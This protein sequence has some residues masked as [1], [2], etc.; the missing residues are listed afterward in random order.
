[1]K[2]YTFISAILISLGLIGIFVTATETPWV[3]GGSSTVEPGNCVADF[4]CSSGF[5]CVAFFCVACS[6]SPSTCEQWGSGCSIVPS[7]VGTPC[8]G[9]NTCNGGSGPSAC[10]SCASD[11]AA[12]GGSTLCCSGL[13]CDDDAPIICQTCNADNTEV[14]SG[15]CEY[16]C[17]TGVVAPV[18]D[19]LFKG[20]SVTQ[21]AN[22]GICGSSCQ[23]VNPDNP[24][25]PEAPSACAALGHQFINSGETSNHGSYAG[26]GTGG[27]CGEDSDEFSSNRTVGCTQ[28]GGPD[29]CGPSPGVY[30]YGSTNNWPD[31]TP[32]DADLVC[33]GNSNDSVYNSRCFA[34]NNDNGGPYYFDGA[35]ITFAGVGSGIT[36]NVAAENGQW[37][38]CDNSP[39]LA[40]ETL[41]TGRCNLPWIISGD[42]D[43]FVGEYDTNG[44]GSEEA[45]GDDAN[46]Y[47]IKTMVAG[48][49]LGSGYACCAASTDCVSDSNVCVS[50]GQTNPDDASLTCIVGNQFSNVD[51]DPDACVAAGFAWAINGEDFTVNGIAP[52]DYGCVGDD[53][54]EFLRYFQVESDLQAQGFSDDVFVNASCYWPDSCVHDFGN[55]GV[56]CYQKAD[57]WASRFN[58]DSS[59]YSGPGIDHNLLKSLAWKVNQSD[60]YEIQIKDLD[61]EY[62]GTDITPGSDLDNINGGLTTIRNQVDNSRLY[63]DFTGDGSPEVCDPWESSGGNVSGTITNLTSTLDL[64]TIRALDPITDAIVATTTSDVNGIYTLVLPVAG[65][66]DIEFVRNE[67]VSL[68]DFSVVVPDGGNVSKSKTMLIPADACEDDCSLIDDDV[69]HVACDGKGLCQFENDQTKSVCDGVGVGFVKDVGSGDV[70][71]CCTGA[72][73]Q[74]PIRPPASLEV[75]A[76]NLITYRKQVILDG[77]PVVMVV[78]VFDQS[79][80]R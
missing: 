59:L 17:D 18:C 8:G 79:Q 24:L 47:A 43:T 14:S 32:N 36:P 29:L 4:E 60:E 33:C 6:G 27:C 2:L 63:F 5:E 38:D 26:L 66:Y 7:P 1:M 10:V 20:S 45:C 67:Y 28:D 50:I 30:V 34:S 70:V 71:T 15:S 72:I 13:A 11:G 23:F 54:N 62:E 22:N 56:K 3:P 76:N 39:G 69:C 58:A 64:T 75:C 51:L 41:A 78:N 77:E 42:A 48:V 57:S 61:P 74:A 35:S 16:Q 73:R 44:T 46:E 12:C 25:D 19:E 49:G 40:N 53:P 55:E 31:I 65:I 37:Y 52:G 21:G 80:C 9:S 68:K